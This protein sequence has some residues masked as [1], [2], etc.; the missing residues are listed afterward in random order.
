[1]HQEDYLPDKVKLNLWLQGWFNI[2]KSITVKHNITELK[3]KNRPV[4]LVG[5]ERAFDKI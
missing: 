5:T 4:A 2:Y 1:M 3:V